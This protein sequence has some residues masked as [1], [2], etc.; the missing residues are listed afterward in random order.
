MNK[1]FIE[2]FA[3]KLRQRQDPSWGNKAVG[4]IDVFV[5][6]DEETGVGHEE[7]INVNELSDDDIKEISE[8]MN[9][10]PIYKNQIDGCSICIN[11]D[12]DEVEYG[13]W[14]EV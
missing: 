3:K 8:W 5:L 7:T 13:V 11:P 1:I 4:Y 6:D 2:A 12:E 9:G 10:E 14:E